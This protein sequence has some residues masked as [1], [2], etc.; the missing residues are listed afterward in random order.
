M[1]IT[2]SS[3]LV[4][5][6]SPWAWTRAGPVCAVIVS[7][8]N[9]HQS[10][11]T[12]KALSLQSPVIS[13]S[14]CLPA[15]SSTQIPEPWGEGS[16]VIPL[17]TFPPGTLSGCWSPHQ[18]PSAIRSSSDESRAR[19]WPIRRLACHLES[20]YCCSFSSLWLT[21]LRFLATSAMS[22]MDLSLGRALNPTRCWLA[23]PVA[24]VPLP[25]QYVLQAGHCCGL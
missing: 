23:P 18:F 22:G 14:Y 9:V 15:S 25:C 8:W 1:G 7:D 2:W 19:H 4:R 16:E 24:S 21:H 11:C 13:V 5:S 6:G 17:R 10:C 20:A 3:F 12:W